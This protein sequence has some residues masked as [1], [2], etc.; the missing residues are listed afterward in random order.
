MHIDPTGEQAAATGDFFVYL[1]RDADRNTFR[2]GH[3][4]HEEIDG[5]SAPA[6]ASPGVHTVHTV[7]TVGEQVERVIVA[8]NLADE[9]VAVAIEQAVRA[10]CEVVGSST[11][12][13]PVPAPPASDGCGPDPLQAAGSEDQLLEALFTCRV[14]ID[15]LATLLEA[16]ENELAG[17]SSR[18]FLDAEHRQRL[19][20]MVEQ[21][22][23]EI[24]RLMETIDRVRAL[25]DFAEW[26][27]RAPSAGSSGASVRTSDLTHALDPGGA[28]R[29]GHL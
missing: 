29:P 11:P 4:H 23:D 21:R 26:A 22:D 3:A 25:R 2:A 16:A 13:R 10:A 19:E 1:M 27:A 6:T 15:R 8:E 9:A 14:E 28:D 20:A 5:T 12:R 7:R 18:T 24:S 17:I